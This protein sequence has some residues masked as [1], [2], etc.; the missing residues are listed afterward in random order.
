MPVKSSN[1]LRHPSR[2]G[3]KHNCQMILNHDEMRSTP[4]ASSSMEMDSNS[5]PDSTSAPVSTFAPASMSTASSSGVA[6]NKEMVMTN[7]RSMYSETSM[8]TA[9]MNTDHSSSADRQMSMQTSNTNLNLNSIT[10]SM[11]TSSSVD[12]NNG[13]RNSNSFDLETGQ[14]L[15]EHEEKTEN[16][17]SSQ[18]AVSMADFQPMLNNYSSIY[19]NLNDDFQ[20]HDEEPD[21][22]RIEYFLNLFFQI[23][24]NLT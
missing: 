13:L 17:Q 21:V 12:A 2:H 10:E 4:S 23:R 18:E 11:T 3:L 7:S 15:P 6:A 20:V 19:P 9:S 22:P 1:R 8:G 16:N 5:A 14:S 24:R